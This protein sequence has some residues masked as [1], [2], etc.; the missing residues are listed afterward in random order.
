M[1]GKSSPYICQVQSRR[2]V[3]YKIPMMDQG[4]WRGCGERERESEG[5]SCENRRS[6]RGNAMLLGGLGRNL[7]HSNMEALAK[8]VKKM[9]CSDLG[10][11]LTPNEIGMVSGKYLARRFCVLLPTGYVLPGFFGRQTILWLNCHWFCSRRGSGGKHN[12][13]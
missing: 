6:G 4:G 12:E 7:W 8:S 13:T 3:V 2:G 10:P 1:G 9:F 11:H 5:C